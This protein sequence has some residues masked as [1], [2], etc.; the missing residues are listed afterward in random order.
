MQAFE[1]LGGQESH[2]DS[3]LQMLETALGG[4]GGNHAGAEV[5]CTF[6]KWVLHAKG[7]EQ[8]R[9]VYTR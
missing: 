5:A 1:V 7:I 4:G 6:V 3:L 2:F 8:A 9:Q